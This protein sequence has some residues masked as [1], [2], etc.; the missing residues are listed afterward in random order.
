MYTSI[1]KPI[2]RSRAQNPKQSHIIELCGGN[3]RLLD[4][5]LT[6]SSHPENI[7]AS[8]FRPR[9]VYQQDLKVF[10]SIGSAY[11]A[12]DAPSLRKWHQSTC[13]CIFANRRF[14]NSRDLLFSWHFRFFRIFGSSWMGS[15]GSQ[16]WWYHQFSKCQTERRIRW[17]ICGDSF[18]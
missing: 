14:R 3:G 10:L 5:I 13:F 2:L 15:G 16:S 11:R 18:T 9:D 12:S 1:E 8:S 4:P 6:G 17:L 7:S